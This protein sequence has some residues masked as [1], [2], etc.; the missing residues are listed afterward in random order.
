MKVAL[1][2]DPALLYAD[3]L[4][5]W[6]VESRFY[7]SIQD[8]TVESMVNGPENISNSDLKFSFL[9]LSLLKSEGKINGGRI[10]D[11]GGGIGR[12]SFQV[13]THFFERIDIIDPIPHFLFKA[14]EIIEKEAIIETE[15]FGIEEWNPSNVYDAFWVQW[16]L[17]HLT[18]GD[19]VSFL[20]R[21]KDSS[22]Q[23]CLMFLKENV[24]GFTI[25][26]DITN[27]EYYQEKKS[28]CRTFSHFHS[29]I[30]QSGWILEEYRFQPDLPDNSIPVILFILKK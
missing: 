4:E 27:Y 13:L 6:Y 16:V 19:I 28:I 24:S 14:R 10:A 22:T 17:C 20:K 7:W 26:D 3:K 29:L 11:C 30:L 9:V 2:A 1:P 25:D 12:V 23:N 8:S 5:R 21:C 18:D 15:Q